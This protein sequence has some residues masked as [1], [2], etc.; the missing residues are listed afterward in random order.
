M[1]NMRM[2]FLTIL[3]LTAKNYQNLSV[4]LVARTRQSWIDFWGTRCMMWCISDM[5]TLSAS[6]D[7]A[8]KHLMI[9]F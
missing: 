4:K 7:T 1:W 9:D 2:I 3:Y 5:A 6:V 8:Q